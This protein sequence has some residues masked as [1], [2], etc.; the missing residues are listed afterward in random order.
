MAPKLFVTGA[1]AA[2]VLALSGVAQAA[3]PRALVY[4]I[5]TFLGT[6]T[7]T[8]F[9][10][11]GAG[12]STRAK[13]TQAEVTVWLIEVDGGMVAYHSTHPQGGF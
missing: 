4:E 6:A 8:E 5:D 11:T 12:G 13:N 7:V 9:T 2:M 10:N 3:P 1:V